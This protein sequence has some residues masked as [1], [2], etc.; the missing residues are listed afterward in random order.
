MNL[1]LAISFQYFMSTECCKEMRST[2]SSS[3]RKHNRLNDLIQFNP[4]AL[5]SLQST[6]ED[7]G[8]VPGAIALV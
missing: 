3:Q 4:S 2:S 1:I 8:T 6:K 5:S 7:D